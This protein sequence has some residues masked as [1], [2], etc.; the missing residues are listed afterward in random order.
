[1]PKAVP[2]VAAVNHP[3]KVKPE[4]VGAA[5]SVTEDLVV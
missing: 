2:P 3:A 1:V 4:R 5:G